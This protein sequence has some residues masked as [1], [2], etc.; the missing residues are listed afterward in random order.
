MLQ[1][2]WRKGNL[3]TLLGRNVNRCSHC[4]K[5]YGFLK[6]P[7]ELPYN[8]AILLTGMY[9]KN[10]KTLIWKGTYTPMFTVAL[11]T[12]IKIQKQMNGYGRCLIYVYNDIL[13]SHKEW[14]LAI[15]NNMNG[16]RGSKYSMTSLIYGFFKSE[17]N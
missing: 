8:L 11:F 15:C 13:L 14:N 17:T 16:L 5:Q 12:I 9:L 4:G 7:K 6:T 10:T 3:C 2:M 1:K